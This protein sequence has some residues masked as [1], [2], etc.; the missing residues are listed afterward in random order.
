VG[1]TTLATA[2]Q[3]YAWSFPICPHRIRI[4]LDVIGAL[5]HCVSATTDPQQG[6][7][8][9]RRRYGVT[10]IEAYRPLPAFDAQSLAGAME[11]T[12]RPV[13]GYYRIRDGCAFILEPAE[14]DL[15]KLAFAEAGSVFLL[16]ERRAE[17]PAEGTFAFWRSEAFVSNLPCPFPIDPAI[18]A[19]EPQPADPVREKPPGEPG[20]MRRNAGTLGLLA[21]ALL[22]VWILPALWVGSQSPAERGA[23]IPVPETVPVN[24]QGQTTTDI[25]WDAQALGDA[26][27]GL[28]RII[29]GR[30]QHH[31]PLTPEQLRLGTFRYTGGPGA[32]TVEMKA[33]DADGLVFDVPTSTHAATDR[34]S[35]TLHEAAVRKTPAPRPE[36]APVRESRPAPAPVMVATERK[37]AV[38]PFLLGSAERRLP[39]NAP[40]LADAPPAVPIWNA[41]PVSTA[42]IPAAAPPPAPVKAAAPAAVEHLTPAAPERAGNKGSG[43]LIWTGTLQRRG[44]LELDQRSVSVGS[45]TGALPGVPV[46]VTVSPAEFGDGGLTVYTTDSKLDK[47]VEAPSARNGWNRITYILDP[48]RVRQIAVLESPNASNRFTHLALRSDARRCSMLVIDWAAR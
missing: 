22:L 39:A 24:A 42:S 19:R 17:G 27:N 35:P 6:L 3:A 31:V 41:A 20:F 48:E 29:D 40:V 28:L 36:P 11:K 8:I 33:L 12:T 1:T 15:C 4:D 16:V 5:Q 13:V 43:R 37:A 14:I 44:V 45:L 26:K 46:N 47:H 25:A 38:K 9:G 23:V 2:E 34:P 10:L 18:L 32:I 7:L 30:L 21:A